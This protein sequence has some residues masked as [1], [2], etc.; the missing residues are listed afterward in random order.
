MTLDSM[1]FREDGVSGNDTSSEGYERLAKQNPS[2][3]RC[4]VTKEGGPV[5]DKLGE[6]GKMC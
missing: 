5:E 1:P 3:A 2:P 4:W 6:I